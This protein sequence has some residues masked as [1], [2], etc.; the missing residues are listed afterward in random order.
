MSSAE[1]LAE[2]DALG[3][4]L[5]GD[6]GGA[7]KRIHGDRVRQL[8]KERGLSQLKLAKAVGMRQQGIQSIED[9]KS[10]RPRKLRELAWALQTTEG[11]L[12][13]ESPLSS[14]GIIS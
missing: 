4:C 5:S 10:R 1:R 7:E 12:L 11:W 14:V 13:G 3:G 9:G 2:F 6:D 8:R